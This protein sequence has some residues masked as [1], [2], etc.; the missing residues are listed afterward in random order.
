MTPHQIGL[1]QSS[2]QQVL[3]IRETAARLFYGRLFE[4][5][6]SLEALFKGDMDEQGRK[7]FAMLTMVVTGLAKLEAIVPAVEDLGRRHLAYGVKDGDYDTV[8]NALLWTLE[9]GLGGAFTAEVRDAWASAYG[10]LAATMRQAAA[11]RAA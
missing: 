5:D 7:L 8:G 9:Q 4:T 1:V 3:P 6:P 2:W 10:A 11:H